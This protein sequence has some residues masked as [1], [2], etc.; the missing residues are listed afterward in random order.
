MWLLMHSCLSLPHYCRILL[1]LFCLV[2]FWIDLFI[3]L[4]FYLSIS[5][6]IIHSCSGY[7][8]E[9][10]Q[11][12]SYSSI[13]P[14]STFTTFCRIQNLLT[15]WLS[16]WTHTPFML[17]S[18]CVWFTAAQT[19]GN[20]FVVC[21]GT[22]HVRSH[23]SPRFLLHPA[24]PDFRLGLSALGISSFFWCFFY[25]KPAGHKFCFGLL[26]NTLIF[27]SLCFSVF[28]EYFC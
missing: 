1:F 11:L 2:I 24:F 4:L 12:F 19:L 3:S 16:S 13:L 5:L 6:L 22:G 10:M 21:T 18:S 28:K 14:I 15:F 27:L 7:P 23:P 9:N 8:R 17:G 26:E 25:C 20:I